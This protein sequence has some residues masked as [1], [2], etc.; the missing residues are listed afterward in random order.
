MD[1]HKGAREQWLFLGRG[2]QVLEDRVGLSSPKEGLSLGLLQFSTLSKLARVLARHSRHSRVSWRGEAFKK[3]LFP[4]A[5]ADVTGPKGVSGS[6]AG[7]GPAVGGLAG[8]GPGQGTGRESH[9]PWKERTE[10]GDS[11]RRPGQSYLRL[12]L[13]P[14]SP[15]LQSPAGLSSCQTQPPDTG[16]EALGTAGRRW[17]LGTSAEQTTAHRHG[18][19]DRAI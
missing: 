10:P 9:V 12:H 17:A 1:R 4:K 6:G 13:A 11:A 19:R 16:R 3:R 18:H 7:A 5:G 14:A 8:L 2:T 15:A